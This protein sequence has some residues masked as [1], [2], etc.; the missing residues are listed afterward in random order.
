MKAALDDLKKLDHSQQLQILKAISKVAT[1]PLP[2]V[3]G[4]FG[5]PLGNKTG[6]NL[7]GYCKI[8]LLKMGL[9]VVYKVV[10]ENNV[11]RIIIIS[12]RADD[13]VYFTAQKR[14]DK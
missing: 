3:E 6:I 8:K 2:Q 11:M 12:A 14:I 4:G 10:R 13:E 5:K 9:R 7:V 1:N